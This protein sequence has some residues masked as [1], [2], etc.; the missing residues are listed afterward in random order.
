MQQPA[1]P[2]RASGG[3]M[4]TLHGQLVRLLNQ[5][6]THG[7]SDGTSSRRG[8]EAPQKAGWVNTDSTVGATAGPSSTESPLHPLAALPAA[9]A[10][11]RLGGAQGGP[12]KQPESFCTH[13][14]A[15]LRAGKKGAD[16]DEGNGCCRCDCDSDCECGQLE[17]GVQLQVSTALPLLGDA[18]LRLC[19]SACACACGPVPHC[20][21]GPPSH[22]AELLGSAAPARRGAHGLPSEWLPAVGDCVVPSGHRAGASLRAPPRVGVRVSRRQL[23]KEYTPKSLRLPASEADMERPTARLA[24]DQPSRALEVAA[25]ATGGTQVGATASSSSSPDATGSA[26]GGRPPGSDCSLRLD[27]SESAPPEAARG[28]SESLG[29][30]GTGKAT[31]P[32]SEAQGGLDFIFKMEGNR[33]TGR[34]SDAQDSPTTGE[35]EELEA[36]AGAGEAEGKGDGKG[37]G[38]SGGLLGSNGRGEEGGEGGGEGSPSHASGNIGMLMGG[39]L[40]QGAAVTSTIPEVSHATAVGMVMVKEER[41]ELESVPAIQGE[42]GGAA[43][44]ATASHLLPEAL[45]VH[46]S[47][48]WSRRG[49]TGS[50]K[51][52]PIAGAPLPV[53]GETP[54]KAA[55]AVAVGGRESVS[56]SV[57]ASASKRKDRHLKVDGRGRRI[58]MPAACAAEIFKLTR[59]LGHKS[60]G[61][62]IQWLLVQAAPAI[63]N[64]LHGRGGGRGGGSATG[65]GSQGIITMRVGYQWTLSMRVRRKYG[66]RGV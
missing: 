28:A 14:S 51:V 33:C 57:S 53:A 24:D 63:A 25:G 42:G 41:G 39:Q 50:P 4:Q 59:A 66:L 8:L 18:A 65:R 19:L 38:G 12:E 58:R 54:G 55:A 47:P 26:G 11:A 7:D 56:V 30:L 29:R 9:P 27:L 5:D 40:K 43:A 2:A 32:R 6:P 16:K 46:P 21:T 52:E 45:R 15:L 61:E 17:V 34:R 23:E 44:S 1:R 49:A 3:M 31:H 35:E 60:D 48:T 37:E 36:G 10:A 13:L 20:D 64:T 22:E 62:T